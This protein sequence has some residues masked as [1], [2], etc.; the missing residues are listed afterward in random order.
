MSINGIKKMLT[1]RTQRGATLGLIAALCLFVILSG[2]A[3]IFL[4]RMLG[5]S[6]ELNHSVEAAI[7]N[8]AKAALVRPTVNVKDIG[9]LEFAGLGENGSDEIS[10]YTYNKAVAAA[11]LVAMNAQEEKTESARAHA[12]KMS[13]D[14]A[15]L[16]TALSGAM[17][18]E[19]DIEEAFDDF[20][21][22][23]NL[24]LLGTKKGFI[25][26]APME[27]AHMRPGGSTNIYFDPK[28][29]PP[30]I[31]LS[32]FLN[33][34]SGAPKS[35]TGQ[36]YVR[37]YV[38]ITLAG[39]TCIGTPVFPNDRAHQV[40]MSDFDAAR[41]FGDE[42]FRKRLPPNA[43]KSVAKAQET[44]SGYYIQ[45]AA[46]AIVGCAKPSGKG[47]EAGTPAELPNAYIKFSNK[48]G[49]GLDPKY[50][51]VS[52]DGSNDIFNKE[53]YSPSKILQST[54]KVFTTDEAQMMAWIAFNNGNGKDPKSLG[55]DLSLMRKGKNKGQAATIQDLLEIKKLECSCTHSKYDGY[56]TGECI[57][58][59]NIMVWSGNYQRDQEIKPLPQNSEYSAVEY[60]KAAVLSERSKTLYGGMVAQ[61]IWV[62]A[63]PV[64]SG[65]QLFDHKAAYPTPQYPVQFGTA[66]TPWQLMNQVGKCASSQGEQIFDEIFR[67]CDQMKPGLTPAELIAALNSKPLDLGETCYLFKNKQGSLVLDSVCPSAKAGVKADGELSKTPCQAK[68]ALNELAVNSKGE[69]KFDDACYSKCIGVEPGDVTSTFWG[70]DRIKWTPSSGFENLLGEV[71]F[72][73]QV[74]TGAVFMMPN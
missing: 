6:G 46:A 57:Q 4:I 44:Q 7:R 70:I 2:L 63:P 61:A 40:A 10:L 50:S 17:R 51:S 48:P 56:L 11:M 67:R 5:G 16:G 73:N 26:I 29:I 42:E 74:P 34:D 20:S 28:E 39:I 54:N 1:W 72:E 52:S 64:A 22:L 35:S 25:R 23:N 55:F 30:S 60:C 8:A 33:T 69:A 62:A 41:N 65:M 47:T 37:G 15:K 66:G 58:I 27:F 32:S 53:L 71:E 9:L 59:D 45:T 36:P 38:P 3:F 49:L 68:Y 21:N 31:D 43:L 19:T 12:Q 18:N 24:K 14:L 13:A